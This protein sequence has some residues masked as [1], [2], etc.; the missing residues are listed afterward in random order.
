MKFYYD[1]NELNNIVSA[2]NKIF[3]TYPILKERRSLPAKTLS[4]GQ[5]QTLAM[6]RALI[7]NPKMIILDEPS[8]ALQPNLVT[9]IME[10]VK[11]LRDELGVA[12]LLVEQN[13]KSGLAIADRGY[14]LAAGQVVHE[15]TGHNLLNN[16]DLG[17]YYLGHNT[18][19]ENAD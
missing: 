11:K 6:A 15:D 14:I 3:N 19:P 4:G 9:E 1:G 16:T 2:K 8:A 5:R 12:V 18:E 7:T 17:S 13:A 10:H